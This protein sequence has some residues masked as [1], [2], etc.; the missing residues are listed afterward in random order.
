MLTPTTNGQLEVYIVPE[1]TVGI[2]AGT[3][4]YDIQ[5]KISNGKTYTLTRGK[6]TFSEDV[7]KAMT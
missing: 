1:D 5:V 4:Q 3:Y 2:D 6:I 7:T